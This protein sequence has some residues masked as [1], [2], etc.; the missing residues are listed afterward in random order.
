MSQFPYL[1]LYQSRF[2]NNINEGG[3]CLWFTF[4][5]TNYMI[6]NGAEERRFE[7]GIPFNTEYR[8]TIDW[9]GGGKDL[10]SGYNLYYDKLEQTPIWFQYLVK[11]AEAE[12]Q[13]QKT[14]GISNDIVHD[15]RSRTMKK[16][17]EKYLDEVIKYEE[18]LTN[19]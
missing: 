5:E 12:Y 7:I 14:L 18:E 19:F 4:K 15:K 3:D 8:S 6:Q 13:L 9:H 1:P 11:C 16:I 17:D 10:E 2:F